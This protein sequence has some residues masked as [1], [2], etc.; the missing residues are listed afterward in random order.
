MK[1][2]FLIPLR[3]DKTKL[4]TG[5][6]VYIGM[7]LFT[8]AFKNS[9]W[10][11]LFDKLQQKLAGWKETVLIQAGKLQLHKSTNPFPFT[12]SRCLKSL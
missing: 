8:G 1:Y 11:P 10:D 3:I 2:P 7:P 4:L 6:F 12:C 9:V 5:A